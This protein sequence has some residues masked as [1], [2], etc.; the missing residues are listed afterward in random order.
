MSR[1]ALLDMYLKDVSVF[2]VLTKQEEIQVSRKI[3]AGDM[4]ARQ[5]MIQSNL[6]LVVSVARHFENQGLQILDIIEE[7][8]IGLMR[9][10]ERFDPDMGCR[11]STY[12]VHWIKQAIRR[13]LLEKVKNIRVPA[14]M[15][16]LVARWKSVSRKNPN[17]T[18]IKEICEALQLPKENEKLVK[19]I[20]RT[21]QISGGNLDTDDASALSGFF[22]DTNT[23]APD[24]ALLAI[25]DISLLNDRLDELP[26]R[27]AEILRYRFG[28]DDYPVL[29]LEEI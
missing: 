2:K 5:F 29:T 18:T 17:L 13:A 28:L 20:I 25:E 6:R 10:V 12:G 24:S 22:E 19:R 15:S 23:D 1:D 21:A 8:N 27:G 7:G 3:R 26:D 14:Y 4:E 9:A 11:F 16:E